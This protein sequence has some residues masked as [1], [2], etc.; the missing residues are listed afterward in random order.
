M[1]YLKT[2]GT[3][4]LIMDEH[5]ED[6]LIQELAQSKRYEIEARRGLILFHK[7]KIGHL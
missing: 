6:D 2:D 7:K 1:P 5:S 3:M 4:V